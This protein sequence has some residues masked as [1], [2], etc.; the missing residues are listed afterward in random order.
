MNR[1]LLVLIPLIFFGTALSAQQTK[2]PDI[3]GNWKVTDLQVLVEVPDEQAEA[4]ATVSQAFRKAIFK[5]G[6]DHSFTLDFE[7]EEMNIKDA[8]WRYNPENQSFIIQPWEHK[9]TD[10]YMLM[11]VMYRQKGEQ[12]LFLMEELPFVLLVSREKP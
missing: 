11:D 12:V 9:D 4:M 1:I 10:Q 6:D 8:H 5:F 3:V 7:F 2:Q